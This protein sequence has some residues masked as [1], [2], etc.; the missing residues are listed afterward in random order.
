MLL[1]FNGAA[2][3]TLDVDAAANEHTT[4]SIVNQ[5]ENQILG[6]SAPQQVCQ[7]QEVSLAPCDIISSLSLVWSR[8]LL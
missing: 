5:T 6:M 2:L 8:V 7:K 1:F 4:F 3:I